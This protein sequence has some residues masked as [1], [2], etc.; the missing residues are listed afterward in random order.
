MGEARSRHENEKCIAV[1]PKKLN[2]R[3]HLTDMEVDGRAI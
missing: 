2:R 3:D 1:S